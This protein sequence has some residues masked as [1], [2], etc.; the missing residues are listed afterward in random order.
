MNVCSFSTRD[1]E[2]TSP[3]IS[4][5]SSPNLPKR[6]DCHPFFFYSS[7]V[8]LHSQCII[9]LSR[10]KPSVNFTTILLCSSTALS[11][12]CITSSVSLLKRLLIFFLLYYTVET[13]IHNRNTDTKQKQEDHGLKPFPSL[14]VKYAYL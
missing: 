1:R 11:F 3:S 14:I 2:T 4:P 6:C 7:S 12:H 8:R 9:L 10:A 13:N 5:L